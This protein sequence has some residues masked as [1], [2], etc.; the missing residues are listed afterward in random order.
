MQ[1]RKNFDMTQQDVASLACGHIEIQNERVVSIFFPEAYVFVCVIVVDTSY[2]L[3]K[4][5]HKLREKKS[6][7]FL[8]CYF[9]NP[10]IAA[11]HGQ[12]V[13]FFSLLYYPTQA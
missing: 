1:V 8:F 6:F 4:H 3:H 10:C 2:N 13:R 7:L 5:K 9:T 12:T 11:S